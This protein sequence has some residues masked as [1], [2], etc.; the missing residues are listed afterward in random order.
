M[1]V[2]IDEDEL[3]AFL[4]TLAKLCS[5]METTEKEL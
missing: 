2:G 4:G 1:L 3:H 5:N